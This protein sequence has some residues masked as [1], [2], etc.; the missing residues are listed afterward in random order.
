MCCSRLEEH[1]AVECAHIWKTQRVA[2]RCK[3]GGC[4]GGGN[5]RMVHG[6]WQSMPTAGS[7]LHARL[8]AAGRCR[9]MEPR[10][11]M[12]HVG[13]LCPPTLLGCSDRLGGGHMQLPASGLC[14][15]TAPNARLSA[16]CWTCAPQLGC[17]P[18]AD[19][20]PPCRAWAPAPTQAWPRREPQRGSSCTCVARRGALR[21]G[22]PP[23]V[24]CEQ[25]RVPV[26]VN[27]RTWLRRWPWRCW[28]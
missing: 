16:L 9:S 3:C 26:R 5:P 18:R 25:G 2:M 27:E 4:M 23:S 15:A 10:A 12:V 21:V 13:Q 24:A 17:L 28:K 1:E 11:A 14:A 6:S 8:S 22:R 20:T 7:Q 19:L